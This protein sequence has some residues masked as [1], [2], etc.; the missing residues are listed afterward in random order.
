MR[1]HFWWSYP[2]TYTRTPSNPFCSKPRALLSNTGNICSRFMALEIGREWLQ[3][4]AQHDSSHTRVL[5]QMNIGYI[6]VTAWATQKTFLPAAAFEPIRCHSTR[7]PARHPKDSGQACITD[8]AVSNL[9]WSL[10]KS[11]GLEGCTKPR[12][13]FPSSWILVS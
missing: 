5:P 9:A 2:S 3:P 1:S 8:D 7:K 13:D 12:S 10:S 11:L 6:Q 4:F